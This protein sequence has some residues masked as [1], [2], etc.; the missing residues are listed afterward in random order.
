MSTVPPTSPSP[1]AWPYVFPERAVRRWVRENLKLE[2]GSDGGVKAIFRFDG[3]TC[4]NVAFVLNY[5][6]ILGPEEGGYLIQDY[7]I[8]PALFSEGHE[9]MCCWQEDSNAAAAR[10][11]TG[12]PLA[13]QP[14][15]SVLNWRPG[16][17]PAGCLCT[18]PSRLHKWQAALETLHCALVTMCAPP[19]L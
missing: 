10:F 14:L 12:L 18:E 8:E 2:R 13:S 3:S 4:G 9:R 16:R 1:N 7:S 19:S 5:Q 11:K 17:S 15:G 6:V